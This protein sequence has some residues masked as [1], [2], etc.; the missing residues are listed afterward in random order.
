[1]TCRIGHLDPIWPPFIGTLIAVMA[2]Q[3]TPFSQCQDGHSRGLHG[4]GRPG[5]PRT[6]PPPRAQKPS[7][8]NPRPCPSL[9]LPGPLLATFWVARSL[10]FWSVWS[11][12]VREPV[13]EG[14][15]GGGASKRALRGALIGVAAGCAVRSHSPIGGRQFGAI[16]V[17]A[18]GSCGATRRVWA[19]R[20]AVGIGGGIGFVPQP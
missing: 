13:R 6:P 3:G 4:F 12:T 15:G 7:T 1:L 17:D 10:A 9:P 20:V 2:G 18:R 19:L 14:W 5:W 16:V 8:L 11:V